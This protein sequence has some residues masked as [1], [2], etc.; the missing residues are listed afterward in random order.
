MADLQTEDLNLQ[1][2]DGRIFAWQ[3][4]LCKS[5]ALCLATFIRRSPNTLQT[6]LLGVRSASFGGV[7]THLML[8]VIPYISTQQRKARAVGTAQ[9]SSLPSSISSTSRPYFSSAVWADL[10]LPCKKVSP[11]TSF[12]QTKQSQLSQPL[13]IRLVLQTPHSFIALLWTCSRALMSFS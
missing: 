8:R 2:L 7:C 6:Q 5:N 12:L 1:W 3:F 9:L 10:K 4:H 13:L 11:E